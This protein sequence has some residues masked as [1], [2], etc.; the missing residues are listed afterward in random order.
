MFCVK[1]GSAT[2]DKKAGP[3]TSDGYHTFEELYDHRIALWIALLRN[4]HGS[5]E[6]DGNPAIWR[7]RKHSDGSSFPGWFLL[8][9][10]TRKG[11]MITYHL[12]DSCWERCDFAIDFPVSPEFDGHT[13][14]DVLERLRHL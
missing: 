7:S 1:C 12:P 11:R 3:K 6:Y 14:A 10:D 13:S 5:E 4:I 2:F 8:G 9:Y